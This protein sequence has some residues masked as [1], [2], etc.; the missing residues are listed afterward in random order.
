MWAPDFVPAGWVRGEPLIARRPPRGGWGYIKRDLPPPVYP[1][2][3]TALPVNGI[4]VIQYH[5]DEA[6]P[7]SQWLDWWSEGKQ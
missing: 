7:V 1:R 2:F 6:R 5:E 3:G 4:V